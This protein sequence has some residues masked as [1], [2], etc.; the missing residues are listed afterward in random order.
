VEAVLNGDGAGPREEIESR[1]GMALAER[2]ARPLPIRVE[3]VGEIPRHPGSGK[4]RAIEA[5]D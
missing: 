2:G 3:R 1:L 5:C 4:H